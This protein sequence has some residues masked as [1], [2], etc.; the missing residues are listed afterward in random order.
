MSDASRLARQCYSKKSS[1]VPYKHFNPTSAEL[2]VISSAVNDA[3]VGSAY[4]AALSYAE[5]ITGLQKGS[6]SWSIVRLYYSCFYSLRALLFL[7]QIVPF[8]CG[9]EM[10][11]DVKGARF[12]KGGK[13]S[14]HWDWRSIRSVAHLSGNWF[15]SSDS[16]DAYEKL[17]EYR[18]NVNYTHGFTDP[19]FHQCL[20]SGEADLVK[21]FRT[22][23]DDSG[24]IYTYLA[25]HLAIAYPTK[26]IF[27]L[28]VA[29]NDSAIVLPVENIAH[30][31]SIWGVRDRCPMS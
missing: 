6:I 5:A 30:L 12:I 8:N 25:D 22:Y 26:L 4:A 7:N 21:R 19:N 11:L 28:N 13:S 31:K 24:F 10:L 1:G 14:H 29:M 27:S 17:R 18:E 9:G 23:R 3:V 15:M 16:Q 2:N 20:I